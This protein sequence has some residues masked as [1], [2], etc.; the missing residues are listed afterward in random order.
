MGILDESIFCFKA[1]QFALFSNMISYDGMS[2][3]SSDKQTTYPLI[4]SLSS[5]TRFHPLFSKYCIEEYEKGLLLLLEDNKTWSDISSQLSSVDDAFYDKNRKY[6]PLKINHEYWTNTYC[7]NSNT[8]RFMVRS[9]DVL[10]ELNGNNL[11]FYPSMEIIVQSNPTL[12][13]MKSFNFDEYKLQNGCHGKTCIQSK[14]SLIST[15]VIIDNNDESEFFINIHENEDD[16]NWIYGGDESDYTDSGVLSD[17]ESEIEWIN[18][19]EAEEF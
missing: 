4:L 14:K 12:I 6:N 7:S 11:K 18:K 9:E 13:P 19:D 2:S 15:P 3:P 16:E 17:T 5:S 10:D 1:N 8:S